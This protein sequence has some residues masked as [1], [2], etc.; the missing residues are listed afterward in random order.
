MKIKGGERI[1]D[2]GGS[3]LFWESIEQKL[4]IT[5]VNLPGSISKERLPI[6]H[7]FTFL[8]GDACKLEIFSD[9]QFDIAFS[10]SVIEH[11]GDESKRAEFAREARRLAPKYW[12]QTPS[13]H[14]PIEAHNH[15]PFWWYYPSKL[16]RYFINKWSKKLPAWTEMII[17]TTVVSVNELRILFPD[18]DLYKERF[19]GFVKSYTLYRG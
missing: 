14:F 15:M 4:D 17:G 9:N 16:K 19:F 8:E 5:I 12:V 18:G 6:Q 7:R 10:N 11:V 3:A 2:L 13:I 1:V